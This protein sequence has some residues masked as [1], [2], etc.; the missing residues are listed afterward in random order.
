MV[1]KNVFKL[2]KKNINKLLNEGKRELLKVII[3]I[4]EIITSTKQVTTQPINTKISNILP[5]DTLP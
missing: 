5:I 4:R 2:I 1:S 3:T